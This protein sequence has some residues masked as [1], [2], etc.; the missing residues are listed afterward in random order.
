MGIRAKGTTLEYD[1]GSSVFVAI[2]GI[3]TLSLPTREV[4]IMD[5]SDHDSTSREKVSDQ[6]PDNGQVTF[7]GNYDPD[8]TAHKWLEDNAGQEET[9][10]VTYVDTGATVHTF[11]ALIRS[12]G[13][14]ANYDGTLDFTCV[15]E[16]TGD[17]TRT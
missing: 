9:F 10:R 13:T 4:G 8:G 11:Q 17:I 14:E 16:V 6:L 2:D 3:K 15:L 1:S 5:V 7:G 12:F